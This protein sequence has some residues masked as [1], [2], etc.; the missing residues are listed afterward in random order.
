[1]DRLLILNAINIR[2]LANWPVAFCYMLTI[3]IRPNKS[4]I[5]CNDSYLQQKRKTNH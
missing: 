5:Q 3:S 1:M 4:T 2:M